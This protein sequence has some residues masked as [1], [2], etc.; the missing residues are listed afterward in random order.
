M[1]A[2]FFKIFFAFSQ[3]LFGLVGVIVA[4]W[5]NKEVREFLVQIIRKFPEQLKPASLAFR[6]L[7][8]FFIKILSSRLTKLL[9]IPIATL[10]CFGILFKLESYFLLRIAVLCTIIIIFTRK[11]Q[12]YK[13]SKIPELIRSLI[14][15]TAIIFLMAA[16]MTLGLREIYENIFTDESITIVV[17]EFEATSPDNVPKAKELT[18][19]IYH[20]IENGLRHDDVY[21]SARAVKTDSVIHNREEAIKLSKKL[22]GKRA[23][24]LWGLLAADSYTPHFTF[25]NP[26]RGL[27]QSDGRQSQLIHNLSDLQGPALDLASN[28]LSIVN[29][30]IGLVCYWENNYESAQK[31]FETAAREDSSNATI[32]F[33]LGNCYYY[34]GLKDQAVTAFEKIIQH[35]P[36]SVAPLNNLAV[37]RLDNKDYQI[38]LMLLEKAEGID[39]QCTAVYNNLGVLQNSL[40]DEKRATEYFVKAS[41]IDSRDP[42]AKYNLGIVA[43]HKGDYQTAIKHFEEATTSPDASF[44]MFRTLGYTC[45]QYHNDYSKALRAFKRA[46]A[47]APKDTSSSMG[48]ALVYVYLGEFDQATDWLA[49]TIRN[50]KAPAQYYRQF[51]DVA[52]ENKLYDPAAS[53]YKKSIESNPALTEIYAPLAQSAYHLKNEKEAL[54]YSLIYLNNAPNGKYTESILHLGSIIAFNTGKLDTALD[55]CHRLYQT[56]P[57]NPD[58]KKNYSQTLLRLIIEKKDTA[59]VRSFDHLM[60]VLSPG[61]SLHSEY[62]TQIGNVYL[63]LNLAELAI[64]K[65]QNAL[66]LFPQNKSARHNLFVTYYNIASSQVKQPK[67]GTALENYDLAFR[68]AVKPKD[69]AIIIYQKAYIYQQQKET[70]RYQELLLEFINYVKQHSLQYDIEISECLRSAEKCLTN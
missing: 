45:Y 11:K 7:G 27:V 53:F 48:M 46:A 12:S 64:Q 61:D 65:F 50:S 54:E 33:Y 38:A 10:A 58:Y 40:G 3:W 28:A 41:Q 22:P 29:F 44:E 62:L 19:R 49:K 52:Y 17:S 31:Y 56:Q 4:I 32:L 70:A 51:G 36:F 16:L 59:K 43:L 1:L 66:E 26:P 68:I 8:R 25:I 23:I 47:L 39:S 63:D 57:D 67:C 60:E 20:Y 35:Q 15:D 21:F 69:K 37:V 6:N 30:S 18:S 9:T 34:Q 55:L 24:V 5:G 13:K 14:S 2:N 42:V